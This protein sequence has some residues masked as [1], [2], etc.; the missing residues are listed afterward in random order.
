MKKTYY[1][2]MVEI[3]EISFADVLTTSGQNYPANFIGGS[4]PYMSDLGED[5]VIG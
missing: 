3:K 4:D 5:W 1:A 2:P